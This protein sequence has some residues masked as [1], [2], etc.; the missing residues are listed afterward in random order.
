MVFNKDKDINTEWN[1]YF[2]IWLT[3]KEYY[4]SFIGNKDLAEYIKYERDAMIPRSTS[5]Y[6]LDYIKSYI[7]PGN[8]I[9]DIGCG[10]GGF[11]DNFINND[12]KTF[13]LEYNQQRVKIAQMNGRNVVLG[14][15]HDIPFDNRSFDIII[16]SE[17][18]Q[19]SRN[20]G[21][22]IN[23]WQSKLKKDGIIIISF[24]NSDYWKKQRRFNRN[25]WWKSIFYISQ[26]VSNFSR[27]GFFS[28]LE[29]NGLAIL[30]EIDYPDSSNQQFWIAI[31]RKK[32]I[33]RSNNDNHPK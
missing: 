23:H 1:K 19:Q 6:I 21:R 32:N 31:C 29:N 11:L 8:S 15:M 3:I 4:N 13:G 20:P 24:F 27:A 7:K 28:L 2:Y 30:E 26:Y 12:T 14:D 18:L 9:L 17:V 22:L 5:S 25:D 10:E 16:G 33:M